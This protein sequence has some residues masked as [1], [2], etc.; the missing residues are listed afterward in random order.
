[1]SNLD[2]KGPAQCTT[3]G[4]AIKQ[5]FILRRP[6]PSVVS[7]CTRPSEHRIS[8]Y[9]HHMARKLSRRSG[10][11]GEGNA[12]PKPMIRLLGLPLYPRPRR[13]STLR[14]LLMPIRQGWRSGLTLCD[15]R[16]RR[17]VSEK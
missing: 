12:F 10:I 7:L 11:N 2:L 6:H 4:E 8:L 1:M 14:H 9:C 5:A 15:G 3:G 16:T 13:Q 17:R